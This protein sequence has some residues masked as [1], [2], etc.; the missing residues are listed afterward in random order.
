MKTL[1]LS[2]AK[3]KYMYNIPEAVDGFV[4]DYTPDVTEVIA[5]ESKAEMKLLDILETKHIKR[6]TAF[7]KP[8][9][10]AVHINLYMTGYTSMLIS[11][12]NVCN[13]YG[14]Q[15]TCYHYNRKENR[16]FPQEVAI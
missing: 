3:S 4:F 15:V 6:K 1:K 8:A 7:L 5:L 2:L 9:N 10:Y 11:F 14:I 16:F 13:K 12:L